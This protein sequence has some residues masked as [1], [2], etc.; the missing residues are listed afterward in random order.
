MPHFSMSPLKPTR[1]CHS[2]GCPHYEEN[3][4]GHR[5]GIDAL[6]EQWSTGRP[7]LLAVMRSNR[8]L[9]GRL[10]GLPANPID[11]VQCI[12]PLKHASN[13]SFLT[14]KVNQRQ[15]QKDEQDSLTG[16]EQHDDA[17][18]HHQQPEKVFTDHHDST[19][20]WMFFA[21][22]INSR[23]VV[24]E[25]VDWH[26]HDEKPGQDDAADKHQGGDQDDPRCRP[27]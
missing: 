22:R 23:L 10:A 2:A 24:G 13:E 20:D 25:I 27:V 19:G 6:L 3:K 16:D 12:R 8:R 7:R 4:R 21:K 5:D 11:H 15:A 1:V 14:G 26:F 17:T 18:D 9:K